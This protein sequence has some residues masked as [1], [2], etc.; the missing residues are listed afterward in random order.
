VQWYSVQVS[1]P[2]KQFETTSKIS[3]PS[4]IGG[5]KTSDSWMDPQFFMQSFFIY[6]KPPTDR[7][8]HPPNDSQWH[9]TSPVKAIESG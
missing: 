3:A 7:P 2:Q 4:R 6:L 1:Q 9:P 8:F 5:T